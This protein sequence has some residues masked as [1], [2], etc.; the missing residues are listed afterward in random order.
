MIKKIHMALVAAIMMSSL[1]AGE[2]G[3]RPAREIRRRY[4]TPE[5]EYNLR[6]VEIDAKAFAQTCAF[7]ALLFCVAGTCSLMRWLG[8]I[9]EARFDR[10]I[11]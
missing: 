4:L 2:R 6:M 5:Q 10:G 7:L 11:R 3:D 1:G 8:L 9:D